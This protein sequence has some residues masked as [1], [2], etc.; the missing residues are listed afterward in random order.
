MMIYHFAFYAMMKF[1]MLDK[2]G[3]FTWSKL[4]ETSRKQ[5]AL[6]AILIFQTFM[7]I[8]F[9]KVI[10]H[11]MFGSPISMHDPMYW[12]A[13]LLSWIVMYFVNGYILWNNNKTK[14]YWDIFDKWSKAK[15]VRRGLYLLG[16]MVWV[17]Y[18][19]IRISD[20]Y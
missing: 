18:M 10:G 7:I 2:N 13:V 8:G 11:L 6:S 4:S 3:L 17:S 16:A 14:P 19:S 12:L 9:W 15:R 5:K 20:K 1:D